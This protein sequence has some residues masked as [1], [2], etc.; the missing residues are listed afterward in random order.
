M[1]RIASLNRIESRNK[2]P[3]FTKVR[4]KSHFTY[5]NKRSLSCKKEYSQK[6]RQ[7]LINFQLKEIPKEKGIK[8]DMDKIER[9]LQTE[10]GS[11]RC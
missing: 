11:E 6:K 8:R 4:N 7:G 9:E 5:Q 1:N 2:P 3:P 10:V